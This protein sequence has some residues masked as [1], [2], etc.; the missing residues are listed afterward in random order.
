MIYD[1][2]DMYG[3]Q[4]QSTGV[5]Q[6]VVLQCQEKYTTG[7]DIPDVDTEFNS[8][9]NAIMASCNFGFPN[10]LAEANK[11]FMYMVDAANKVVRYCSC[12]SPSF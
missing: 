9:G 1:F 6:S 10:T 4:D 12:F 8:W 3:S 11:L 7:A 5:S 2:P